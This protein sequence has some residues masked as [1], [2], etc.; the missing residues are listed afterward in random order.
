MNTSPNILSSENSLLILVDIQAKLK[1]VMP[2]AEAKLMTENTGSLLE[3]AVIL[4]IPVLLTEQYPKGLG[5]T[6]TSIAN[7]LPA[8][9]Q[10]FEKTGFSCCAAEGFCAALESSS[11][12]QIIL[13]GLEAHVCVLQTA[14]ELLHNGY[15][16]YVVEDA[17]CS[18]K[19]EHKFYA[20]QRLQQQGITITNHESVL[21]EW[22]RDARHPDFRSI[23]GLLH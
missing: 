3:A 6:D 12:K 17:V 22:L 16:V 19:A 8:T 18:R 11:R 13:A 9:T 10:A 4:N 14:L 5:A 15:Q 21:F 20:L 23:S 1:A 7:K 2:E